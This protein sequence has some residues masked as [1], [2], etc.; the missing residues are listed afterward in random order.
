M[1]M[2]FNI[3]GPLEVR[4]DGVALPLGPC[5]QRSLLAALLL[6]PNRVVPVDRIMS[7]L[8]D[9]EP[10]RS[11]AANVRTYTS[12]LRGALVDG[13]GGSRLAGRNPG[14]A[15]DVREGELDL[16]AFDRL[17]RSG[18]AAL[19]DGRPEQAERDL[20]AALAL[21]RGTAAEDI[22]RT[23]TL[24]R[25]L[26]ALD[27]SRLAATEDWI[28]ARQQLGEDAELVDVLR[29]LTGEN[30]L[31]ERLWCR[32]V[33]ALYTMGDTG[34]ALAAFRQARRAIV[35][36]LGIEPG[37]E[38]A[39]V[40][41]AVLARDPALSPRAW[42]TFPAPQAGRG[43]HRSGSGAARRASGSKV[44]MTVQME[45]ATVDLALATERLALA[46]GDLAVEPVV[47]AADGSH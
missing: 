31:R 33:L 24:D 29:R 22:R 25:R 28:A 37:P 1:A 3:L 44:R 47:Y 10:P 26:A 13:C 16:D 7:T 18:R 41:E 9:D 34:G 8:W 36:C 2:S 11:A 30:P 43:T 19:A 32:L 35:E 15:V 12:R 17:T 40:H 6:E 23:T 46:F 5:L 39:A 42:S 20:A 27:E 14:Y 4:C 38:L 21:W 45:L